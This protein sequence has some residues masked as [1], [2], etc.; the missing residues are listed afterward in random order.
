MK[1][2]K[3]EEEY[4]EKETMR[5]L[6]ERVDK[7]TRKRAEEEAL[8]IEEARK[9][10]EAEYEAIRIE[11]ERKLQ[12]DRKK[13]EEEEARQI[14]E[15]RIMQQERKKVEEEEAKQKEAMQQLLEM[16][17]ERR[18]EKEKEALRLEEERNKQVAKKKA[19]EEAMRKK[20]EEEEAKQIE[21]L[22]KQMQAV[23]SRLPS[24][25]EK[26]KEEVKTEFIKQSPKEDE[27]WDEY[28][29]EWEDEES[30]P[31]TD[32]VVDVEEIQIV[33]DN[34]TLDNQQTIKSDIEDSLFPKETKYITTARETADV[35]SEFLPKVENE[36]NWEWKD[37]EVEQITNIVT[38]VDE[39]VTRDIED[40]ETQFLQKSK[41]EDQNGD[42]YEW[43]WEEEDIEK[44]TDIVVDVEKIQHV[45]DICTI[46]HNHS[47]EESFPK[48]FV[49]A[50]KETEDVE[51]E[52]IQK[53]TNECDLEWKDEE[54]EQK[55]D[56]DSG[57]HEIEHDE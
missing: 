3:E 28:D 54:L 23:I 52:C 22:E 9:M 13:A 25:E 56:F 7:R 16:R 11:E 33:K 35:E 42:E 41:N 51:R 1:A 27:E 30:E 5:L 49:A 8:R 15:E 39:T 43:E 10:K 18:K 48:E 32:I 57:V 45:E 44:Q 21:L 19:E 2:E 36:Y 37:E 47:F 24:F 26:E 4:K 53:V 31:K 38:A 55:T 46:N 29:W 20:I 6:L 12:Q 40:V 17:E 34:I 50:T 14:E